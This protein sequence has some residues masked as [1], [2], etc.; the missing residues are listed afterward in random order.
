LN[1]L[2]VDSRLNSVAEQHARDM[3]RRGRMSHR[4]SDFS[5]PF[6]RME[7]AG[8]RF[9]NAAENVAAGQTTPEHVMRSWMMSPGH[10]RNILGKASQ[11][12]T[13]CAI[14]STGTF[15]WCVTF[16]TPEPD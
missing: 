13:A 1:A 7:R 12:G 8:Y 11:I 14:G 6:D 3:A 5:S 2:E 9:L 15:F 4:G 10:R 16:G